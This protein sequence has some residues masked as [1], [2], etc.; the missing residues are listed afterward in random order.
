MYCD[1]YEVEIDNC[2]NL[3]KIFN[4]LGLEKI[5]VVDKIRKTFFYLDKYEVAL[6][7]VHQLGYFIE[8]EVKKYSKNPLEEYNSLI[9]LAKNLNLNLDSIDKRGYPYH[10]IHKRSS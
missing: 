8:I 9:K 10:I 1:E 3:D 5:A 2:D 4:I 7:Y 6:D